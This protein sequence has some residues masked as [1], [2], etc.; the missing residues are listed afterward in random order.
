MAKLLSTGD[1]S[2]LGNWRKL[3][4]AFFGEDSAPTKFIQ[5]KIDEQGEDMEVV[6]DEGQFILALLAMNMQEEE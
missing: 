3:S 4:A 5:G 2:T 1:P 6:S